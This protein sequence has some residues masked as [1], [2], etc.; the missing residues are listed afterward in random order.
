MLRYEITCF[1]F[2]QWFYLAKEIQKCGMSVFIGPIVLIME[3]VKNACKVTAGYIVGF[4]YYFDSLCFSCLI[5]L[6][7]KIKQQKK[8]LC[9]AYLL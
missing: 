7:V 6:Y 2:A 4:G 5:V 9:N 1:V 3:T 8:F